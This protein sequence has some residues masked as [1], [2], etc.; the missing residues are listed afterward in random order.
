MG[1]SVSFLG[2][3]EEGIH[4]LL[5]E[6]ICNC[7][8]VPSCNTNSAIPQTHESVREIQTGAG[9]TSEMYRK[10]C[11]FFWKKRMNPFFRRN[12][13]TY[14]FNTPPQIRPIAKTYV[15]NAPQKIHPIDKKFPPLGKTSICFSESTWYNE[16]ICNEVQKKARMLYL[17]KITKGIKV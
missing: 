11:N 13:K 6:Q 4:F 9:D 17:D 16:L 12:E 15:Y 2:A 14:I 3:T 10:T 7:S 8:G 5:E 1:S